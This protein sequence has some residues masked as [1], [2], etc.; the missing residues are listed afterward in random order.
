MEESAAS[1]TGKE[2][3][4]AQITFQEIRKRDGR[5]VPFDEQIMAILRRCGPLGQQP[6]NRGKP[7]RPGD[8]Y[9]STTGYSGV[10]PPWKRSRMQWK[11]PS[12]RMD[13]PGRPRPIFFTGTG[14]RGS[15]GQ[16]RPDGRGQGDPIET[17]RENANISNSPSAKMLNCRGVS[18]NIT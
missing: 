7:D 4:G 11:R 3:T 17:N 15:G 10:I 14:A 8:H 18:K 2:P 6:G 5:V 1:Y 16:V 12:L 9:L 13:M